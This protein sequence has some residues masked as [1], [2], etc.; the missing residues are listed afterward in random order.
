MK[1]SEKVI[2]KVVQ[3]VLEFSSTQFMSTYSD[4]KAY[5]ITTLDNSSGMILLHF[6]QIRKTMIEETKAEQS[7]Q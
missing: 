7:F 3:E 6:I 4:I 2:K 5:T 1:F